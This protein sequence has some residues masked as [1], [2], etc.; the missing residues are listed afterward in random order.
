[1]H[2]EKPRLPDHA[3][4]AVGKLLF[5]D[6]FDKNLAQWTVEQMEGGKTFI[7]DS[8][9]EIEDAQGCTI[10]FNQKLTAPLIIQYDATIIKA[11]GPYDRASDLNCFWMAVDPKNPDDILAASKKRT[12]KF[13]NYH[14]LRLYYVGCGGNDNTTTR[15]R[16]YPGTGHRPLKRKHDLRD[17]NFLLKPNQTMTIQILTFDT[18]ILYIRDGEIIFDVNDPKPY[19]QGWFGLRTV[20]NHMTVDNFQVWSLN[21]PPPK[22]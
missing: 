3:P 2:L 10:W 22:R 15:F 18:R 20:R 9:L 13:Q 12:G 1:M 19:R 5:S 17:K 14:P 6:G 16:R 11:G 7:K 8:K 21:N 4:Y